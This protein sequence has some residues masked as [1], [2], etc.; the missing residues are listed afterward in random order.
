MLAYILALAVGL[1]SLGIY[2]A[3]FFFPE[4]HRKNDFIWSGVGLFYALVLWVCAGRITG[5]VLLG[6]VAGVALLGWSV[7]QTL[8]LRRQLTPRLSQQTELPSAEEVKNTVEEKVSNLSLPER[9]SQLQKR[10]TGRITGAK[11][12][13]Q[14]TVS[15]TAQPQKTPETETAQPPTTSTAVPTAATG[16]AMP[17]ANND[18]APQLGEAQQRVQIIDNRTPIPEQPAEIAAIEQ[19]TTGTESVTE[20]V[21]EVIQPN[22][23][24]PD[25]LVQATRESAVE[26]AQAGEDSL[27]S[28]EELVLT[29]DAEI[30]PALTEEEAIALAVETTLAEDATPEASEPIRPHPPDPEI[31]E[32]AIRDAEEKHQ[33]ASPP[34]PEPTENH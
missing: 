17:A 9:L 12:R 24:E 31:V 2:L 6:Q 3:A 21:P 14:E 20:S 26:D 5:S 19:L 34:D 29:A 4:I 16:E 7:A 32:A 23:P 18:S 11:D 28:T 30:E 15:K 13:V 1:G 33:Q 8:S 22:F 25:E 10:V 27:I